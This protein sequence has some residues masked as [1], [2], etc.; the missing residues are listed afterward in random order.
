VE[1]GSLPPGDVLMGDIRRLTGE[2]VRGYSAVHLFAGIG[3][4][5]LALAWAGWPDSV[6]VLTAGFPCPDISSAG[7]GA[8]LGTRENPTE[9]SGLFWELIR[10]AELF[11]AGVLFVENVGALSRRGLDVVAA[12]MGD[13][14]Y[15]VP[16]AY[17]VGAWALGAPHKR[18]RWWIVG[19]R[20]K[21]TRAITDAVRRAAQHAP[22][23][24]GHGRIN[25]SERRSQGRTA[26][27]WQQP[28]SGPWRRERNEWLYD[29]PP[30]FVYRH[31][32]GCEERDAA[33]LAGGAR[34]DPR[35]PDPTPERGWPVPVLAG[36]VQHEWEFD[37]IHQRGVG[38]AVH[39]IS[40]PLADALNKCGIMACGNAIVPQVAA[41]IAK[42][43]MAILEKVSER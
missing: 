28:V 10:V 18:E 20:S 17:R 40:G 35:R 42:G 8:G 12:A 11:D 5:P 43:V 26:A 33:A 34:F 39:G 25:E 16:D 15:F 41:A 14:G 36:H 30:V 37:R 22:E 24:W 21:P 32:A 4:F 9:R 7:K 27:G 23:G 38:S 2:H 1:D 19:Y 3:G 29:G 6:K 31:G 13:A